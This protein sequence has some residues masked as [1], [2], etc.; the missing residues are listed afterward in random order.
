MGDKQ[1]LYRVRDAVYPTREAAIAEGWDDAEYGLWC[2]R[3][4]NLWR[5]GWIALSTEPEDAD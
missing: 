4:G 2:T 3:D 5:T 1:R